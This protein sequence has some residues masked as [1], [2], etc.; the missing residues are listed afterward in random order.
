LS[1]DLELAVERVHRASQVGAA[2]RAAPLLHLPTWSQLRIAARQRAAVNNG[3][4]FYEVIQHR[5]GHVTTVM[6]DVCGNG[7]S[8]AAPVSKL[9]WVLRQHLARGESPAEMLATLNDWIVAQKTHDLFVTALCVRIDPLSGRTD[10]ASAGHLGPFVKRANGTAAEISLAVGIALGIL[11]A[12]V[13]Q[14]TPMEL[15]SEDALV[16]VTDGITDPLG[17]TGNPLGQAGLLA[18]LDRARPGA[19]SICAALLGRGTSNA[20]DATV[21]VLQLPRRHRRVTP[22]HRSR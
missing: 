5:N 6:A 12:Q 8:A 21:I 9:R 3:G 1:D 13:Y 7:P 19:E 16:L 2:K 11:P 14:Q 10:I 22:V 18:A 15:D 4:D 20:Q 17:T